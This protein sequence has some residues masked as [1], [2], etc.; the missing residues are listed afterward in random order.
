MGNWASQLKTKMER[1]Q[2]VI[3]NF[4]K[5]L[6]TFVAFKFW[7]P[8]RKPKDIGKAQAIS[9]KNKVVL[10]TF[11]KAGKAVFKKPFDFPN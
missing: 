8:V 10:L 1:K 4:G 7:I 2:F 6:T 9:I 11:G 3:F 5:I